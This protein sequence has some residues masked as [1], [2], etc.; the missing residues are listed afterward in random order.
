VAFLI[1]RPAWHRMILVISSVP[2]AIFCNLIRLLVTAF[3][4]LL[5]S[6]RV[7]DAFFHD[8][9]G[10]FMMPLAVMVLLAEV[11]LLDRLVIRT[12]DP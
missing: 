6:A 9:A 2:I 7:A 4:Y 12:S 10:I 3:L 8:F 1:S 11:W 5:T